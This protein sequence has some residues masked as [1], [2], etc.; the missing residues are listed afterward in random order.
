M[1]KFL[2]YRAINKRSFNDIYKLLTSRVLRLINPI[3]HDNCY[4][5]LLS[6]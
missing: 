5:V 2:T 4:L 1:S 3:N 6:S